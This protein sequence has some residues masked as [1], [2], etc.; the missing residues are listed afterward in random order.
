[1]PQTLTCPHGHQWQPEAARPALVCPVCGATTVEPPALQPLALPEDGLHS[2][3]IAPPPAAQSPPR[4]PEADGT[5]TGVSV[6]PPSAW[7]PAPPTPARNPLPRVEGYEI[8][9]ELGRGGMGVVYKARQKALNR[10]VALKMILTG[11]YA[12][13]EQL[14]RFRRE[15]VAVAQLQHPNIIGIH[16]VGE[17]E[18]RPY[19][20]L[21]YVDG[22]SLSHRI[23]GAPQPPRPAAHLAETL[24]RAVHFAHQRGI[25]HRDLKPANILLAAP[26][27]GSESGLSGTTRPERSYGVPKISDFGLA[28]RLDEVA[29]STRTGLVMGSPPYMAPEQAEGRKSAVGPATD[30]YALGAILYELLTGRPPFQGESAQETLLQVLR[31]EPVPPTHL[32]PKV[33]H[34]L[35]TIC[36]KCLAKDPARRYAS[37][38]AMADDLRA[39]LTGETIQARSPGRWERAL[40]W[41][42]RRP[43]VAALVGAGGAALLGLLV[44]GWM[45]NAVAV[46]AVAVA[47]LLGGAWWYNARLQAALRKVAEQH[48]TAE[49]QVERLHLLLETTRR[50]VSV[51]DLDSLLQLITRTTVRL[52]NAERAT[53]YLLDRERK[54]LWSKVAL[55]EGVGEIRVPVGVGIAGTV[56][57][58]GEVVNIPDAYADPRFNPD[59]DRRTGYRTRNLLT[60]PMRTQDGQ[61]LGV[62]Q[63]LNKRGGGFEPD[64]VDTLS[65]LAASAAVAIENARPRG[66]ETLPIKDADE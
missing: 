33:P 38:E 13:A 49:R 62:F 9:S 29:A 48:A 61:L 53:I 20:S 51:R 27:P 39:F 28:K 18:G 47:S 54:E 32:Q 17:Q 52:A 4:G 60:F 36:L 16:E 14:T 37:A 23:A 46:S 6:P 63:I 56:A 31:E 12:G 24:A 45:Y 35:E 22:G 7:P 65:A 66:D 5:W 57:A 59:V 41:A 55:G 43:A 40:Q 21:E 34:D 10:I 26:P 8:L 25:I 42:R 58:T 50:L 11:A 15:A 64:D 1:M 3:S 19:F 2:T 44:G 30:V